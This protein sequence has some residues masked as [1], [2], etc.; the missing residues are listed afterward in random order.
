[1]TFRFDGIVNGEVVKTV[2][3]RSVNSVNLD[4]SVDSKELVEGA[5]YD[6]A[7]V[8]IKAVDFF[9]NLVPYYNEAVT[10]RA[11]GCIDLIGDKVVTLKGGMGGTYVKDNGEKGKGTL[12]I[13]GV[14]GDKTVKFNVK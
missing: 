11:S 9:G 7:T 1:M 14:G 12:T 10:L 8:R 13:C 3:K 5:T 4:V 6:V 2:C